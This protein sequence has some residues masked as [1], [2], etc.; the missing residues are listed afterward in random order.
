[1]YLLLE[2]IG[3]LDWVSEL[4]KPAVMH[5]RSINSH[6]SSLVIFRSHSDLELLRPGIFACTRATMH[7][8]EHHYFVYA[9]VP[10]GQ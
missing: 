5:V 9:P 6:F 1:M 2:D 8:C 10:S 4:V 7:A 3:K